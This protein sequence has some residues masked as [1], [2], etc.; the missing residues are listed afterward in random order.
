MDVAT[1][2]G[3]VCEEPMPSCGTPVMPEMERLPV[4]PTTWSSNGVIE[5]SCTSLVMAISPENMPFELRT[6]RLRAAAMLSAT[7]SPSPL[8]LARAWIHA[9]IICGKCVWCQVVQLSTEQFSKSG[10]ILGQEVVATTSWKLAWALHSLWRRLEM[11]FRFRQAVC[12]R[13]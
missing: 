9:I 10:N 3:E 1:D 12:E 6:A 11:L 4:M 8:A 5:T 7:R 2:G 13:H